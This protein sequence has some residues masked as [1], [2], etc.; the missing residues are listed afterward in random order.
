[1]HDKVILVRDNF[2]SL[3]KLPKK[4][5]RRLSTLQ[6]SYVLCCAKRYHSTNSIIAVS[7]DVLRYFWY[8]IKQNIHIDG[9]ITSESRCI[10]E[11]MI[12]AY[13]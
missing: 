11:L 10:Q 7:E 12:Q 8:L 9:I 2:S 3:D 4:Q 13:R 1:M 5:A 6:S